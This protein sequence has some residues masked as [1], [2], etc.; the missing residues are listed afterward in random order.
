ML[1]VLRKLRRCQLR[2]ESATGDCSHTDL[3]HPHCRWPHCGHGVVRPE[4]STFTCVTAMA[5]EAERGGEEN[6]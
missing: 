6:G 3:Q 1:Q 5:V 2:P 4:V